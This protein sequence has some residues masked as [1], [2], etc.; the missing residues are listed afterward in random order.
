MKRLFLLATIL[1]I[2]A[3]VG[4][5]VV[6]SKLNFKKSIAEVHS[7]K[8]SKILPNKPISRD[9]IKPPVEPEL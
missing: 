8:D 6:Y 9:D 4:S 5:S 1:G 3:V 2:I 7:A